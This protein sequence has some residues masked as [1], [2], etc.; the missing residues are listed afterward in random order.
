MKNRTA[1]LILALAIVAL[2][3]VFA[4]Q[5]WMAPERYDWRDSWAKE[6]YSEQSDQPYGTQVLHNLLKRYFPGKKLID[7]QAD[8]PSELLIEDDSRASYVFV[9]EAL[10]LDSL[11]TRHLLDFAEAGNTVLLSS[12]TIPFD[13]M[14]H[15]YYSECEAAEWNDY[16]IVEDSFVTATLLAPPLE[17][18]IEPAG[19]E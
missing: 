9:G 3:A 19:V 14:F 13:L 1:Y 6:A 18:D 7:I 15:L 2:V 12:K 5:R 16:E 11:S 17:I 10:F 8:L 4:W